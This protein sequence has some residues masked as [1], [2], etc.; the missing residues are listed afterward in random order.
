VRDDVAGAL[1]VAAAGILA[2]VIIVALC[3]LGAGR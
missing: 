2:V 1:L 3:G